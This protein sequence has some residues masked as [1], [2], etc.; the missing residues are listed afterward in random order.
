MEI[1]TAVV[2]DVDTDIK[3]RDYLVSRLG[4]STSLIAK[5]KYDNVILNG[6]PVHMRATVRRGD[7]ITVRFP[8]EESKNIE[9][10]DIPLEVLYEDEYIILVNKPRN[11]PIHP[12]RGNN[13][14]TLA[15]A[16][17]AYFGHPFVYRSITRLD[18]DTSGIVLIAK[19]QLSSAKLS[20]DVRAGRFKKRYL[21]RVFGVP[22]PPCGRID[23]P[24]ER[25]APGE[26]KRVVRADGKPSV[27]EYRTLCCDECGNA[28]IEV[29]PIT[30]RTH[31]IRVHMAYI[32]HPLV[33]DFLY[34]ERTAGET[35]RLHCAELTFPHPASGEFMTV[36][37]EAD[38]R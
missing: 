8:E 33:G 5:V 23:A 20:R 16:V 22:D 19:D 9:P 36:R 38:F 28:L 27:T 32:G 18:R 1:L 17:R 29:S 26:M 25:E 7:V 11:M 3:I 34:G 24:I 2:E 10:I 12:S 31:Q 37:C 35:Y 21:A 13:L 6:V 4:F 30:G 14:P 15:N